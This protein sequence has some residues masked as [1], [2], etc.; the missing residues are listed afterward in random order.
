M[1][2]IVRGK[3]VGGKEASDVAIESGRVVS[4]RQAGSGRADVGGRRL[5]CILLATGG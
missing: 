1:K 3:F 5:S 2:L 4:V